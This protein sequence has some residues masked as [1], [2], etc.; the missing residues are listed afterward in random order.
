LV[1]RDLI[2]DRHGAGRLD[3]CAVGVMAKAP[4]A[5]RSKT[6]LCPPLR[7]GQAAALSGVFL[8]DMTGKIAAASRAAS[9]Q[10]FVAHAEAGSE[11]LFEGLVAEG[12]EFVLADGVT[13]TAEPGPAGVLGFGRC[14][15]QAIQTMLAAGFGAACVL[16]SDSPTLPASVLTHAAHA[17]L[18]PGERIVLGPAEDGGYY[19]L[20]M[21]SAHARLFANIPWSKDT[22]AAATR[23]RAHAI[24]LEIVELPLWYDIDDHAALKRL[25]AEIAAAAI[26]DAWGPGEAPATELALREMGLLA[27][28]QAVRFE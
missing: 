26:H 16:N 9:I 15:L 25:I 19:L 24:G 3:M 13:G 2:A 4:Q 10:G 1:Q 21:K 20:G 11:P 23:A 18:E 5:G 17:L 12:T 8:R 22:V 14:L 28:A 6:R 7:S 27:A